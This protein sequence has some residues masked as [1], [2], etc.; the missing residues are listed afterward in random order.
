MIT[1]LT[2]SYDFSKHICVD[3]SNEIIGLG[4]SKFGCISNKNI[5]TFWNNSHGC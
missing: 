4:M 5:P 2:C 1:D 3:T